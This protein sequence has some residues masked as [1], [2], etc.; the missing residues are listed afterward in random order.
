M[1][2]LGEFSALFTAFLWSGSSLV[3]ASATARVGAVQVN[4]S[5]LILATLYLGIVV[6]L[7]H[8]ESSLSSRQLIYLSVSGVI[9]L[10]V[11]DSFLFKAYKE[12][13]PRITMLI[14]SLS[15][16][17][18]AILGYAFLKEALS[19]HAI[20]GMIVTIVGI[21]IVVLQREK[22]SGRV[23]QSTAAGFIFAF[24]GASGQAI[25]LLFA[26]AAFNEGPIDGF[27]A[28]FIRI[29]ASLVV[30]I[31]VVILSGRWSDPIRD[32]T[33]DPKAFRLTVVG[34]ILGPFLGISFSLIAIANTS[35]AIAS[36]LMATVPILMLPLAHIVYKERPGWRAIAGASV[37][38]AGVALLFFR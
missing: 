17:L 30:L 3:F 35:V 1:P 9:G 23:L 34:S 16:A 8:L 18:A 33:R 22:N 21:G 12:M 25:N 27:L 38:V 26:K 14:M 10:A 13:G 37:A 19:L 32:F 7:F 20:V 11:G 2:L 36:T 28:T 4:I 6:V 24:A 29:V 15:P 5:R 31:P